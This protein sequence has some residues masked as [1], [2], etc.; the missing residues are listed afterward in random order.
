[1]TS[2]QLNSKTDHQWWLAY[3]ADCAALGFVPTVKQ[4]EKGWADQL[5]AFG[6]PRGLI[7]RILPR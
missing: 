6:E 3:A 4:T 2:K 5:R 1:M 7:P